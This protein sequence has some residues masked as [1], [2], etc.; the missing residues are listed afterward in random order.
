MSIIKGTDG[1]ANQ[2]I[3]IYN[4]WIFDLNERVAIPLCQE[5]L[6]CCVSTKSVSNQFIPFTGE[7]FGENSKKKT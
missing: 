2:A 1:I 6:D 5:G 4:N 7:C 3:G